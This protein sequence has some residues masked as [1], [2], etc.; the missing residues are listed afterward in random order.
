MHPHLS[1]GASDGRIRLVDLLD[2]SLILHTQ[3]LEL[4]LHRDHLALV[5]CDALLE[6]LAEP[7]CVRAPLSHRSN[8]HT[9]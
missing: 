1:V 5:V 2:G 8:E 6:L 9:R 3:S 4:L 7:D